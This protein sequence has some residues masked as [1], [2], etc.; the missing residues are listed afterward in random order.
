MKSRRSLVALLCAL[1]AWAPLSTPAA[2]DTSMAFIGSQIAS[3]GGRTGVYVLDKAAEAL[4]ARAWLTDHA[5]RT[6]DAQYFIWSTDNIGILAAEAL[7]RAADRGVRVR[8]IVDDLMID[9]P[10]KSL[11]ALARHPN[12]EIRIYNPQTSV[13][14]PLHKRVF[15]VATN[16]RGVNQ[17]M[18]NKTVLVDGAIAL[19]GGRNMAA[20]YYDY[21]QE[22]NF[23]D[24]D[25]LLLGE[26]VKTMQASFEAFWNS[27]LSVPVETLYDG[28]RFMQKHVSVRNA[29]IEGIYRDLHTYAQTPAH[30]APEVHADIDNTPTAFARLADAMIWTDVD[31]VSDLPGKN[32]NKFRLN[33]GGL[34]TA[35]LAKLIANA[36]RSIVIQ[37]P[38]LVLSEP[39]MALFRQ[40]IA[41]GVQVRINTNSLA[42]SDNM[43]A[44]SGYRNQRAALLKM[45]LQI[46]EYRPDS[47]VQRQS[48]ARS[49]TTQKMPIFALHAKT[50]VVD[51]Q[52]VYIGTYNLDPRSENLNTEAG[53][54]V[55]N[56][57][58]ARAVEAAIDI[59]MR[60]GN[61][62]NAA[63]D[64]PD[65]Y[66][67]FGKRSK[68][69]F[70]QLV[71]IKPLL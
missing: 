46:Y 4:L 12:I 59:D 58:L 2:S 43:Q 62:W 45:G 30:F 71:P 36:Q 37:S 16:V 61:S 42:S 63:S 10:D 14:I 67:S 18:H 35:A 19:T 13:G 50:L 11:L 66:V 23:R 33:G 3:H 20:E 47:Q 54:I 56:E 21:N 27:D 32:A 1:L 31:F 28:S 44:F 52:V 17:R 24:R 38:Y 60:P 26:V 53:V 29:E 25:A 55:H 8:V 70:W 69:R 34:M 6:I 40:A 65:Q 48:P 49:S 9:A 64:N 15:N 57:A 39:A 5:Q 51:S 41:R 22:Y 68:A 7:L